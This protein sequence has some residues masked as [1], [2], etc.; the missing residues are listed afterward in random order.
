MI[1]TSE[2]KKD[3][4]ADF[5]KNG[6]PKEV[7]VIEDTPPP[8]AANTPSAPNT[9]YRVEQANTDYPV[10]PPATSTRSKRNRRDSDT[11]QPPAVLYPPSHANT[12]VSGTTKRRKKDIPLL[13]QQLQG[14]VG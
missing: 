1:M 5:Y 14:K 8:S 6:I 9:S 11:G 13:T 10:G 12:I 7:I 4:K 3:W 2:V